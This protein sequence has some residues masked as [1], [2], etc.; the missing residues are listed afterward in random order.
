MVSIVVLTMERREK[1]IEECW[2]NVK[3]NLKRKAKK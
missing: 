3:K 1:E 2:K